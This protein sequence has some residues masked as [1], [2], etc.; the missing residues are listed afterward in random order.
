MWFQVQQSA[1]Y[2]RWL[3]RVDCLGQRGPC[4]A[5]PFRWRL[6]LIDVRAFRSQR[7]SCPIGQFYK[8]SNELPANFDDVLRSHRQPPWKL[9]RAA[10]LTSPSPRSTRAY[11]RAVVCP[12]FVRI[13]VIHVI[14]RGK[15]QPQINCI[16]Q[17]TK[18]KTPGRWIPGLVL[19]K[20][21][22]QD[23]TP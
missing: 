5:A 12:E 17:N 19:S 16:P 11:L 21:K 4:K 10:H 7:N 18:R 13:V 8:P 6:L 14:K 23:T 2:R 20:R 15:I 1:D 3:G 9:K 22:N